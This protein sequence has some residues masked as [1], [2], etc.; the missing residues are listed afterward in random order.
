MIRLSSTGPKHLVKCSEYLMVAN[1]DV[2]SK[3][4]FARDVGYNTVQNLPS[5]LL[6]L[7]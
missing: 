7:V 2:F 1:V 6:R 5:T 3:S 4:R